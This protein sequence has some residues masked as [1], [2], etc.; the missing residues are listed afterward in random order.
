MDDKEKLVKVYIGLPE[1]ESC[2]SESLW[3]KPLGDDLYEIRNTPFFAFDLH[4]CDIVRAIAV[5]PELKPAITEVVQRRGHKT[6]RIIF[7]KEDKKLK[8]PVLD[9]LNEMYAYYEEYSDTF[10]AIDVEP[11]GDYQAV[12]DY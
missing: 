12:C 4:F 8:E 3:A 1:N 5:S 11:E 7:S 10:Y 6:L 9:K 2:R